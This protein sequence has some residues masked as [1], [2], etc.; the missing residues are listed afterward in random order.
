MLALL[1]TSAN[2]AAQVCRRRRRP[3]TAAPTAPEKVS[4]TAGRSVSGVDELDVTRIAITNAEIAGAVVVSPR[5]VLVDGEARNRQPD[6]LVGH[7]PHSVP[8]HRR[9]G[10]HHA[11]ATFAHVVFR[12]SHRRQSQ[13]RSHRPVGSGLD[14]RGDA[15]SGR[16]RQ[17]VH[18]E[19]PRHQLAAAARRHHE[20]AGHAA[21]AIRRGEP[22]DAD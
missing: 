2:A 13:R 20:P 3:C 11:R 22:T 8:C 7:R 9:T 17:G 18:V 4:L 21:G 19:E 10:N 15:A 16:N 14:Y 6:R 12:R 5:E 1:V